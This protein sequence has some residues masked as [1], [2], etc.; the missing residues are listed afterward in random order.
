MKKDPLFPTIKKSLD[1]FIYDE[2]GNITRN[3]IVTIGTLVMI[4]SLLMYDEIFAGHRSH[5]SHGSH[6]SN[7]HSNHGSHLN[8][9][10]ITNSYSEPFTRQ[11]VEEPIPVHSNDGIERILR[12]LK[13]LN[14]S[15]LPEI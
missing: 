2:E 9:S 1:D 15:D 4:M 13:N 3:K 12:A 6:S 10:G 11:I 5:S 14:A 8:E 7:T